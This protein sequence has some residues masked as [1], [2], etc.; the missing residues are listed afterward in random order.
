MGGTMKKQDVL[1]GGDSDRRT[2]AQFDWNEIE[3]LLIE[4]IG[5]TM[6]AKPGK[7]Q[8]L[9]KVAKEKKLN[10]PYLKVG[11][12]DKDLVFRIKDESLIT[13][14]EDVVLIKKWE[15]EKR[16]FQQ[17]L[18]GIGELEEELKRLIN[19][20]AK[21][22]KKVEI[23]SPSGE[24]QKDWQSKLDLM[25]AQVKKLRSSIAEIRVTSDA[26]EGLTEL[27]K[28]GPRTVEV[29]EQLLGEV[30]QGIE[31]A[32]PTE[33]EQWNDVV[34]PRIVAQIN[35]VLSGERGMQ[36]V[37]KPGALELLL[38]S[39]RQL[40][41]SDF[42]PTKAKGPSK[43][44][45]NMDPLSRE[46]VERAAQLATE[47]ADRAIRLQANNEW[48]RYEPVEDAPVEI[49]KPRVKIQQDQQG[50]EGEEE[51]VQ[52]RFNQL[53]QK[54]GESL[55]DP[56]TF[57]KVLVRGGE[58]LFPHHHDIQ[59]VFS[60]GIL[61]EAKGIQELSKREVRRR[62]DLERLGQEIITKL[63]KGLPPQADE[64]IVLLKKHMPQLVEQLQNA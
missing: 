61:A 3:A 14:E 1:L 49:S 64:L 9:V 27:V 54:L 42:D 5:H 59:K 36:V 57:L 37:L 15:H 53:T 6:I 16:A 10:S 35:Q 56:P 12:V 29:L 33:D 13:Y 41:Q 50:P 20:G 55:E 44:L 17:I 38:V 31:Q 32:L 58:A 8:K 11:K 2:L 63:E 4:H 51:R 21:L 47:H 39:I 7:V 23:D 52:A 28:S 24:V 22:Q 18:Q 19:L 45:E 43:R 34:K 30:Q 40:H 60:Q 48:F 26:K 25:R 62:E 46:C